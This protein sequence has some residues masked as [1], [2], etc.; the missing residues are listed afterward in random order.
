[1]KKMKTLIFSLVAISFAI[2][3]VLVSTT[4]A[5][6]PIKV[7]GY[8]VD[9]ICAAHHVKDNKADAT[10]FSSQH[11]KE[12]GLMDDCVKSGYGIF[13]E[14]KWY[15]FDEKG[16]KLALAIFEKTKNNDQIKVTVEGQLHEGKIMV[17]KLT[18]E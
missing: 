12:C 1:M 7:S 2:S 5:H 9:K 18:A 8:L 4:W 15:E 14:G 10:K 17:E 11:T 16:S 13:S 6:E 3:T